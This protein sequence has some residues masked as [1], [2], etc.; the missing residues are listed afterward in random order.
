MNKEIDE[1]II[2]SILEEN[3]LPDE[4]QAIHEA[5]ADTSPTIPHDA[6]NWD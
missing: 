5:K 1:Y 2:N 3:A 4:I 6:I